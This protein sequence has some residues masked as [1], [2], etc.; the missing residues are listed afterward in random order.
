MRISIKENLEHLNKIIDNF[1]KIRKLYKAVG[2][3][4]LTSV[5]ENFQAQGRPT[6]WKRLSIAT[7]KSGYKGKKFKKRGGLTKAF[8]DHVAGKKILIDSGRLKNS[9]TYKVKA[10]KKLQDT[11]IY[12]GTNMVYAAIHQYGG[13]A[14]RGRKVYIPARPYLLMQEQDRVWISSFFRKN[15]WE[16]EG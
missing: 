10:I 3:Y 12:I 8:R 14:G 2:E 5:E 1:T 15:L 13:Y 11:K 6:R 16:K 7:L 9:I 4:M